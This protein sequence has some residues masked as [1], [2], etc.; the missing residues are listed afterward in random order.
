M[1]IIV[2]YCNIGLHDFPTHNFDRCWLYSSAARRFDIVL[3]DNG[4]YRVRAI[5]AANTP[6]L[7]PR[8]ANQ[9]RQIG[10][11]HRAQI[12]AAVTGITDNR[13]E[14]RLAPSIVERNILSN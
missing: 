11:E 6:C 1:S 2:R 7:E 5:P 3:T 4:Q 14:C 9:S 13:R 10:G 12:T 8:N